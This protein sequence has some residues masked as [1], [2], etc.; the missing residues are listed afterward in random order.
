[1]PLRRASS[2]GLE[3]LEEHIDDS[4]TLAKNLDRSGLAEVIILLR[5]A[6]NK[7][8]WKLGE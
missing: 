6:R 1:M 2:N 4:L 3:A 8:V 7:V 5:K